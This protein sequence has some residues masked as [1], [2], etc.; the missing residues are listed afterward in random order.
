[1][2]QGQR[3]RKTLLWLS[4]NDVGASSSFERSGEAR[5]F[6]EPH[7]CMQE[8]DMDAAETTRQLQDSNLRIPP[9]L[10]HCSRLVIA[11]GWIVETGRGTFLCH[12]TCHGLPVSQ[13]DQ[14]SHDIWKTSYRA[15]RP[16]HRI[17]RA[18]GSV[19]NPVDKYTQSRADQ[20]G[21][22]PAQSAADSRGTGVNASR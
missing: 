14:V 7:V 12:A 19:P 16:S 10:L 5:C 6:A 8:H 11:A 21:L 1:M 22:K 17:F 15:A 20:P 9:R 2:R 3:R 4:L 13:Y 18:L